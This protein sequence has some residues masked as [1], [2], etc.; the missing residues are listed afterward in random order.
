[1]PS[2]SPTRR[3]ARTLEPLD[4]EDKTTLWVRH[5]SAFPLVKKQP[6]V[7]LVPQDRSSD[8]KAVAL[9][10]TLRP[11]AER[12]E[13]FPFAYLFSTVALVIA[14]VALYFARTA[15]PETVRPAAV[16]TAEVA[17]PPPPVVPPSTNDARPT[18][19]ATRLIVVGKPPIDVMSLPVA[20]PAPPSRPRPRI[21]SNPTPR[22]PDP[23]PTP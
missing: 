12:F 14:G 19:S 16:P 1:V 21:P 4:D 2:N 8:S 17:P 11:M 9:S 10:K 22:S 20:P 7:P 3:Y 6:L 15:P 23:S 5:S 13:R 18:P